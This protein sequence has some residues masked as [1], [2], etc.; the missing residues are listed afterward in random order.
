MLVSI[1]FWPLLY[2]VCRGK[3]CAAPIQVYTS[4]TTILDALASNYSA[5]WSFPVDFVFYYLVRLHFCEISSKIHQNS[6]RIF[7]IHINNQT[8]EYHV[9]IFLLKPWCWN[10]HLQILHY[11]SFQIWWRR[12]VSANFYKKWQ[13]I[14]STSHFK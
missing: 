9:D 10:S 8:A 13:K 12:K 5:R 3:L 4:A 7:L 11:K 2:A 14:I 6:Q 1:H